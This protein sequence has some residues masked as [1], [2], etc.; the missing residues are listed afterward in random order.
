[1]PSII[2]DRTEEGSDAEEMKSIL[3]KEQGKKKG[4]KLS[5]LH[6]GKFGNDLTSEDSNSKKVDDYTSMPYS[7]FSTNFELFKNNV[8]ENLPV[9]SGLGSHRNSISCTYDILTNLSNYNNA[10]RGSLPALSYSSY[11][12]HNGLSSS[13]NEF[14]TPSHSTGISSSSSVSYSST[15]A[16][17][18][19][20]SLSSPSSNSTMVNQSNGNPDIHS[21]G[22]NQLNFNQKTNSVPFSSASTPSATASDSIKDIK[23]DVEG[24]AYTITVGKATLSHSASFSGNFK[25]YILSNSSSNMLNNSSSTSTLNFIDNVGKSTVTSSGVKQNLN[26]NDFSISNSSS[27]VTSGIESATKIS[28]QKND[29]EDK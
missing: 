4:D 16:S 13:T 11:P 17:T 10:R 3:K 23:S 9:R 2:E 5:K 20:S 12:N 25:H 26:G 6:I 19:S 18:S 22:F 8:I 15:N 7:P 28:F 1:M 21:F 14:V 29:E 27:M 24:S